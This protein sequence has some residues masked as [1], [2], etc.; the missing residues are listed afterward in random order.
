MSAILAVQATP[1]S[2]RAL[3]L[4][5]VIEKVGFRRDTIYR[6]E[7]QGWFPKHFKLSKQASAW[8]EDEI[9]AFLE[10]RAAG[11]NDAEISAL[12]QELHARRPG[13]RAPTDTAAAQMAIASAEAAAAATLVQS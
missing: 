13:F 2:R 4:S 9:D 1:K 3:R 8:F 11:C 6:G 10:M 12:V 7:R 5:Q